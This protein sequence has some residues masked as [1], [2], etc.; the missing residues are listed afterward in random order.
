MKTPLMVLSAVSVSRY[1]GASKLRTADT[2][3]R[4][5]GAFAHGKLVVL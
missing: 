2:V 1:S 4:H 3:P 5:K